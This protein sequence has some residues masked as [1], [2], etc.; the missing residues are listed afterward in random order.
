MEAAFAVLPFCVSRLAPRLWDFCVVAILTMVVWMVCAKDEQSS[1]ALRPLGYMKR[2][3]H[4]AF[5]WALGP[6]VA[7][8][9]FCSAVAADASLSK[10][11]F[12]N[13]LIADAG[14][15]PSER[16]AGQNLWQLAPKRQ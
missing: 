1:L 10:T 15:P 13:W 7:L 11:R 4:A 9:G 16:L 5:R 6:V 8:V 2:P 12:S 3:E 14:C